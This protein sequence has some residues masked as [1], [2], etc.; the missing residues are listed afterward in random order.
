MEKI[1]HYEGNTYTTLWSG[2]PKCDSR[3]PL[4]YDVQIGVYRGIKFSLTPDGYDTK[5]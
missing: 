4:E 5:N 2:N 1:F 3:R